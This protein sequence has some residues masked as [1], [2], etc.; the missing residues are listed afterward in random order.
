MAYKFQIRDTHF[1]I[2]TDTTIGD[3][4]ES[5]VLDIPKA[6]A[7]FDHRMLKVRT[8]LSKSEHA[9]IYDKNGTSTDGSKMFNEPLIECQDDTG[10][11]FTKASFITWMRTNTGFK[12]AAGSAAL[13]WLYSATN[14]TELSTII[15]PAANEGELAIVYNSQG[16]WLI[17]RKLKGV[18]IYQS[19]VWEYANQELQDRLAAKIDSVSGDGVDN[20]DTLNPVLTFPTPAEIGA[21][22]NFSENTAFNKNFGNSANEVLEG[23]TRTINPAEIITVSNQSGTNTG[24][25]TTLTIQNKRPLKT[26]NGNSLEGVGDI[27]IN[28]VPYIK[29]T[30]ILT[31]ISN[32]FSS[33]TPTNIPG[34]TYTVS[35]LSGS[36]NFIFYAVVLTNNDQNEELEFYIAKNGSTDLNQLI[37][38][39]E[40]KNQD[41]TI[42]GT[43]ILDGL[44]NGDVI[45]FQFDTRNDNVDIKTRRILIQSWE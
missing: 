12:Q 44:V 43:F 24:D 45:T 35:G 13:P 34:M 3:P 41:Q 38:E 32:N 31:S 22:P 2:V 17:N 7:Y 10:T 8:D 19:G 21:K 25:E 15:A 26:V 14:Y 39:T 36:R 42:Q 33:N 4:V 5:I 23:D 11:P 16:T 29:D 18:Y 37:I 28:V 40:R 1:L 6:D 20:T 27:P 9:Y 30:L